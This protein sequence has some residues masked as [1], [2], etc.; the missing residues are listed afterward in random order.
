MLGLR[1]AAGARPWG[2]CEFT[3]PKGGFVMVA[4]NSEPDS[5]SKVSPRKRRANRRNA[6]KSTGPRSPEGKQRSSRHAV[7]HDDPI[8]E[9]GGARVLVEPLRLL[10]KAADVASPACSNLAHAMLEPNNPV[11][12]MSRYQ[13][14][15]QQTIFR[16]LA[17]LEKLR[18]K[19]RCAWENL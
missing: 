12:R 14:R 18:G 5:G 3:F 15:L 4:P 2:F 17:E 13:Q 7:T 9:D 10:A 8:I 16:C 6:R 19:P 1:A 11:E